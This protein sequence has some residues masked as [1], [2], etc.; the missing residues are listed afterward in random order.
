MDRRR[1]EH[2]GECG[3]F[4]R[5]LRKW[6]GIRG[7]SQLDLALTIGT[8]PRHLSFVETG[9]ATPG[10]ALV[11]R[12]VEALDVP[13]RSRNGL[14]T[15]AGYAPVFRDSA[16]AAPPME[17]IRKALAFTLAQQEPYPAIVVKPDWTVIMANDAA[18]RWRRLFI[19]DAEKD[20]AGSAAANAM[21]MFFDPLLLRPYILNWEQCA[22]QILLRL[23]Q[24]AASQAADGPSAQLL[25]ELLAYPGAP[26]A[27]G[28]DESG[29]LP[30]N[31]PLMIV[32]MAKADARMSYF[33]MLTTFGTP[34]DVLLEELRI[35][36]Y[37]PADPASTALFQRLVE[38][39][40]CRAA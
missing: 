18:V 1:S 3:A 15:A 24:E 21:K 32:H 26:E 38:D 5:E 2:R 17:T 11:L 31:E 6:R 10:R 7:I 30:P 13:I 23:R 14:L 39:D 34:H 4:G 22:R 9:R 36:L 28:S 29:G 20:R 37:F 16:L 12:L 8:S 27:A 35:K 40:A 33:S 25:R 19:S